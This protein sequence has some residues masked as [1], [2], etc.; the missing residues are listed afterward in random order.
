LQIFLKKSIKDKVDFV[1]NMDLSWTVYRTLFTHKVP[2]FLNNIIVLD[3]D[4]K[5]PDLGWKNYP[6]NANIVF[7]PTEMAPE[8]CIYEMLYNMDD[9]DDFWDNGLSGYSKEVCFRNYPNHLDGIDDIKEWFDGQKEFAGR[10]YS[11]FLNLWKKR[12]PQLVED[13]QEDFIKKYNYVA[14]KIG[15]AQIDDN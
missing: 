9:I 5:K 3:G 1:Q 7:L 11:K 12:N 2:E 4:V 10:G 15:S 13:F 14:N 6:A 8:R